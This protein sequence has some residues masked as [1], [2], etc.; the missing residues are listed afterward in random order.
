MVFYIAHVKI[1]S[2]HRSGHNSHFH[3]VSAGVTG[4]T[5]YI[6][7]H[8]YIYQPL[9]HYYSDLSVPNVQILLFLPKK[10]SLTTAPSSGLVSV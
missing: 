8:I 7:Q 3:W 5:C 9:Y 2:T 1:T 6:S 10:K 4:N